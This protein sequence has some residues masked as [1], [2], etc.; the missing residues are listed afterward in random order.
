MPACWSAMDPLGWPLALTVERRS[1]F[2]R[3]QPLS[4]AAAKAA[5]SACRTCERDHCQGGARG[6]RHGLELLLKHCGLPA[7]Q[8]N[9]AGAQP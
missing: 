2:L 3:L 6:W 4:A 5:V 1:V 9:P 8:P 7:S